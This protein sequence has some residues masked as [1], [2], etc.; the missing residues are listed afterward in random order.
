MLIRPATADDFLEYHGELPPY[1]VKAFA[2][3]VGGKV[4]GI[5][6]LAYPPGSQYPIAWAD[7]QDM[8]RRHAV[9]LHKTVKRFFSEYQGRVV[10]AA[11]PSIEASGRWLKRL[12]FTPTGQMTDDGE[13]WVHDRHHHTD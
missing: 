1:R 3:V 6:G 8:A 2:G 7:M 12:G 13:V 9:T 11:D 4:V 5:A 10:C